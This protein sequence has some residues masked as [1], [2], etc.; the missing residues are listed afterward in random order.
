MQ[1]FDQVRKML[2]WH[3]SLA[4]KKFTYEK[5]KKYP[6]R[7]YYFYSFNEYHS[8]DLELFIGST[9]AAILHHK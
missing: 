6:L 8:I 4:S 7:C 1:Y 2:L 3:N 9:F 5:K